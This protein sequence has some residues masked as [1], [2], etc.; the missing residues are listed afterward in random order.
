MPKQNPQRRRIR[1]PAEVYAKLG[2]IG[3]I[4]IAVTGRAP[5]F[6]CPAVAAA[7]VDVLRRHAAATGVPGYAWGVMPDHVPLILGASPTCDIVTFV[8]EVKNLAQRE[9]WRRGNKGAFWQT[10]FLGRGD[11]RREPVVEYVLNN[12]E[13]SGLVERWCNYRVSAGGGQAPALQR[14]FG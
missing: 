4:P 2:M 8:G 7:A 14:K 3:S 13:R 6:A 5:V 10:S 1:L 11:E 12:P 9:A